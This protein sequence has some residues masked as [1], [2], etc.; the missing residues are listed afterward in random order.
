MRLQFVLGPGS[1]TRPRVAIAAPPTKLAPNEQATLT[2]S[3]DRPMRLSVQL[4]SGVD[5][6]TEERW[7]R[8]VYVDTDP[9]DVSVRFEDM[10]AVGTT[11]SPRPRIA[12]SPS[13]VLVVDTTNTS[14][15]AAGQVLIRRVVL[16][17]SVPSESPL[18]GARG[19]P[20]V[21]DG[22]PAE[23]IGGPGGRGTRPH[24]AR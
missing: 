7:Q 24:E 20:D 23:S 16:G 13:L 4:R 11:S 5:G 17:R 6:A 12:E 22:S 14:P 10:S 9:R 3:A 8:S 21:R 2:I 1:E 19:D 18:D 15:G